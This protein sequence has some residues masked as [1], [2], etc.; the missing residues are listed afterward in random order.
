MRA[1]MCVPLCACLCECVYV[2]VYWFGCNKVVCSVGVEFNWV[3]VL[4]Y[5]LG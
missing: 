4:E 1:R 5:S 2:C 3:M